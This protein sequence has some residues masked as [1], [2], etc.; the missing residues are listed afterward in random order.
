MVK[1]WPHSS[2]TV[3]R[4]KGQQREPLAGARRLFFPLP[5][6]VAVDL[7]LC[8][9]RSTHLAIHALD[10]R[11]VSWPLIASKVWLTMD[12]ALWRLSREASHFC[13]SLD[14][15]SPATPET[16][17]PAQSPLRMVIGLELCPFSI[18]DQGTLSALNRASLSVKEESVP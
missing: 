16:R 15:V 12:P 11:S 7:W 17:L 18:L 3:E 4:T 5:A 8:A 2:P 6:G 9:A 1:A 10:K 14:R 13:H